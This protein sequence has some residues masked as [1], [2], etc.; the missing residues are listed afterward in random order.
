MTI[1]LYEVVC[2]CGVH[3]ALREEEQRSCECGNAVLYVPKTEVPKVL[4]LTSKCKDLIVELHVKI[5]DVD[6]CNYYYDRALNKADPA[7]AVDMKNEHGRLMS[8]I[9]EIVN[10]LDK[11]FAAEGDRYIN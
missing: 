8:N 10:R 9:A 4:S 5:N 3:H 2:I 6:N 11:L 7:R 1:D